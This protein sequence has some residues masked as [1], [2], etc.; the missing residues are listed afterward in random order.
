[1]FNGGVNINRAFELDRHGRDRTRARSL[2]V[3]RLALVDVS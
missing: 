1:M 2:Q 3:C